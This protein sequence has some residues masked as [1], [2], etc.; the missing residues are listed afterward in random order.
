MRYYDWDFGFGFG[1]RLPADVPRRR[2]GRGY[3]R[4][5]FGTGFDRAFDD[6][7]EAGGY[8]RPR[9]YSEPEVLGWHE[10]RRGGP[11]SAAGDAHR[12][13]LRRAEMAPGWGPADRGA[14]R[15]EHD[16]DASDA[17]VRRAV[18]ESLHRDR[19]VDADALDVEVRAGVVTLRGEVDD[20]LTARYAWDDAWETE[21]VRG[22]VNQIAV[23]TDRAG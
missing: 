19:Y 6:P 12:H 3:D 8:G 18:R 7:G 14:M 13:R 9:R 4:P 21:G 17:D 16:A 22:V 10:G 15:G 11:R 5:T 23:R 2:A 1:T 20:F